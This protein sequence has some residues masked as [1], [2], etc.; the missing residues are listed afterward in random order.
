MIAFIPRPVNSM[1]KSPPLQPK[2]R[3]HSHQTDVP[4]TTHAQY[5]I[6]HI[7]EKLKAEQGAKMMVA[8][9]RTT[10]ITE[11]AVVERTT[12]RMKGCVP[13]TAQKK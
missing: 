10:K 4:T 5:V 12:C 2:V 9:A 1:L 13:V 6:Y 7:S 11:V 3:R 8:D